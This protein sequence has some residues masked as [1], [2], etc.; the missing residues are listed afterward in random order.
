M[1]L[2]LAELIIELNCVPSGPSFEDLLE[3]GVVRYHHRFSGG[4][5]QRGEKQIQVDDSSPETVWRGAEFDFIADG[6]RLE[7]DKHE[8]A[9]K[10]AQHAPYGHEADSDEA[11]HRSEQREH[12]ADVENPPADYEQYRDN[13]DG[14]AQHGPDG[15]EREP[16]EIGPLGEP[17]NPA[18][19]AEKQGK[20]DAENDGALDEF[21]EGLLIEVFHTRVGLRLSRVF[22]PVSGSGSHDRGVVL[23]G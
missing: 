8:R 13:L 16:R 2:I 15:R 10:V 21:N 5:L 14:V 19:Q 11:E 23:S 7:G 9:E 4:E 22:E 17:Q 1:W 20:T 3:E 18:L 12:G 6:E